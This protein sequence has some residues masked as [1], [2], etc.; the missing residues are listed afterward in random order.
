VWEEGLLLGW[1][2]RYLSL[3]A[4]PAVDMAA[5]AAAAAAAAPAAAHT[6]VRVADES[7]VAGRASLRLPPSPYLTHLY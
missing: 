3:D 1:G 7:V 2:V 4:A 5:A 6:A